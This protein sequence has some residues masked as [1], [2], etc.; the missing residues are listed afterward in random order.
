MEGGGGELVICKSMYFLISLL[1]DSFLIAL[2]LPH[3]A[4]MILYWFGDLVS[5][6][7]VPSTVASEPQILPKSKPNPL[8]PKMGEG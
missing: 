1:E 7:L 3:D 5:L 6:N 4:Q 8:T 2:T